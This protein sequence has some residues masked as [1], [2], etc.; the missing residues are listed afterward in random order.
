MNPGDK[1]ELTIER[2]VPRGPG[3]GFAEGLT[4]LV[5]LAAPGDRLA[6]TLRD[7]KKRLAFA[8]IVEVLEPGPRRQTPPCPY[9][10][11]CGGCDFQQLTYEAQLDAKES[12]IRDCLRRIGK[13]DHEGEIAI[14]P[15]PV[16]LGY[17]S[18]ARWHLDPATRSIGYFRRDSH[19]VVDVARCPILTPGLQLG[20]DRLRDEVDWTGIDGP[21]QVEAALGSSDVVEYRGTGDEMQG[22]GL[23]FTGRAGDY[24]YSAGVFFQANQFLVDELIEA[25]TGGS[26]GGLVYDLYCGVGLFTLPLARLF[27]RVIAV[28]S[29]PAAAA[30]ARE[31]LGKAGLT[32]TEV[33]TAP[34]GRFL[35][36]SE[37]GRPDLVLLDPPRS[38][39]ERGTVEQI[40]ALAPQEISYV[41]CEPSILARDLR[42]L[43]D[44]GYLIRKL[45]AIDLF[46]QSHHVETV[47]R[48]SRK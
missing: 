43:L 42:T 20:L 16:A 31:N 48:L 15:S 2:I 22:G 25:A 26:G 46:P 18:R 36:E 21:V 14:V 4:V 17:R 19:E 38:G 10:G 8:E 23:S 3:I 41:S 9:F 1:L 47:A 45:T 11:T 44:A 33:V 34:V 12:I 7:V 37:A 27:E 6:I 35:S 28:E 5:P 40:A 30:F 32:N 39:T 29:E 24:A 13:I